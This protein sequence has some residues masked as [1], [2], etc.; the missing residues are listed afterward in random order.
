MNTCEQLQTSDLARWLALIQAEYREMP[1]LNLTP[2]QM[3]RLWGIDACLC[4]AIVNLL[5]EARI[6]RKTSTGGYVIASSSVPAL[7]VQ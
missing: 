3:Q 1:G 2:P 6:L 4:E 7:A 5:V